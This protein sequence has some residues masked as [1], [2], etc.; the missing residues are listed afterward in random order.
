MIETGTTLSVSARVPDCADASMIEAGTGAAPGVASETETG[1]E[2]GEGVN[3]IA[4]VIVHATG[5]ESTSST[6]NASVTA[7]E[8]AIGKGQES[9]SAKGSVS[10]TETGTAIATEIGTEGET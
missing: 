1:V 8:N 3:A 4:I 6:G 10:G 7:S 5:A 2:T 9:G